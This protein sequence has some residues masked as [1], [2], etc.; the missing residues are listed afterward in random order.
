MVADLPSG[1]RHRATAAIPRADGKRHAPG[2]GRAST[3]GASVFC[4]RI[5]AQSYLR[6]SNV[7]SSSETLE[8]SSPYVTE[9]SANG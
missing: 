5:S 9:W 2:R 6:S 3:A 8:H 1:E 7:R 4:H